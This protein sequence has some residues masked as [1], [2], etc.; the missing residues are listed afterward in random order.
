M[1]ESISKII[2]CIEKPY[3]IDYL[4]GESIYILIYIDTHIYTNIYVKLD[5]QKNAY[6]SSI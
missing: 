5:Q 2:T 6:T 4:K 3:Q 1:T